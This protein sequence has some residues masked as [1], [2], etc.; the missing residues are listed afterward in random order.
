MDM[1]DTKELQ[2]NLTAGFIAGGMLGVSFGMGFGSILLGVVTG[3]A[4]GLALGYA[5]SRRVLPMRFPMYQVRRMLL[6]GALF[7]LAMLAFTLV[8]GLVS[9]TMLLLA[10][11]IPTLAGALFVISIGAAIAS[12]DEMQRRIQTEAIAIGFAGTAVAILPF[13][14]LE[15]FGGIHVN[16]GVLIFIMVFM[17]L[18]G[19]LWT[20]RRYG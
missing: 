9:G 19:K 1:N 8:D 16:W 18:L 5:I 13:A 11:L 6:T 15:T 10:T 7:I 17:W 20:K 3:A 4:F 2:A 12:L 14:L